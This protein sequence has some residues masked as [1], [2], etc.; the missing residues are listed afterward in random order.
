MKRSLIVAAV[1]SVCVGA[2]AQEIPLVSWSQSGVSAPWARFHPDNHVTYAANETGISTI[3]YQIRDPDGFQ[4]GNTLNDVSPFTGIA[5][6]DR[7][8]YVGF[9]QSEIKIYDLTDGSFL[10]GGPHGLPLSTPAVAAITNDVKYAAVG[11]VGGG[12]RVSV[13][14]LDGPTEV[15]RLHWGPLFG[16]VKSLQILDSGLLS[17]ATTGGNVVLYDFFQGRILRVC[18]AEGSVPIVGHRLSPN[19]LFVFGLGQDSIVRVW[20]TAQGGAPIAHWLPPLNGEGLSDFTGDDE[21]PVALST[22]GRVFAAY[23]R[24]TTGPDDFG[25]V[26]FYR[27]SDGA[28]LNRLTALGQLDSLDIRGDYR[29]AFVSWR[30]PDESPP[31]PLIPKIGSWR[32]GAELLLAAPRFSATILNTNLPLNKIPLT[33]ELRVGPLVMERHFVEPDATGA[34]E[35]ATSMTGTMDVWV[36]GPT[37]LADKVSVDLSSSNPVTFTL[38]NG[39]VDGNN[40]VNVADFLQLR[41][42]FGSTGYLYDPAADLNG[43]GSVG[44]ADFLILRQNFG[45]T[46]SP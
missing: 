43:D 34:F 3:S 29:Y 46:G 27:A 12:F 2:I 19:G 35:F 28:V 45:R 25:E 16:D 31:H 41:Q 17:V 22:D 18:F 1:S 14:Q 8:R 30:E 13:F 38:R 39:D 7:T 11:V 44:I 23:L 9:D 42:A 32:T 37:W 33:V 4:V 10:F 36:K 20:R 5:S 15:R 24:G 21:H 26:V 6:L 40:S